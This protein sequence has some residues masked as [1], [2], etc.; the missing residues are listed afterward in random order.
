M[1]AVARLRAS[2][3][4]GC[5]FASLG[6]GGFLP[7]NGQA[8]S[9]VPE[10]VRRAASPLEPKETFLELIKRVNSRRNHLPF[11]VT[12]RSDGEET[13]TLEP[14][15]TP[16][17]EFALKVRLSDS[18]LSDPGAI[19]EGMLKVAQV[20]DFGLSGAEDEETG[21]RSIKAIVELLGLARGSLTEVA[22]FDHSTF[23]W[24]E[25]VRDAEMGSPRAQL[26]LKEMEAGVLKTMGE[27]VERSPPSHW[28]EANGKERI[29]AY[30]MR[31]QA[32]IE[33]ELSVSRAQVATLEAQVQEKWQDRQTKWGQ[34]ETT[35]KTLSE[36]VAREDRAGVRKLLNDYLPWELME[37]TEKATWTEWLDAIEKPDPSRMKIVF[38]GLARESVSGLRTR[39]PFLLTK[40]YSE[41]KL[42]EVERLRSLADIRERV[43]G[44]AGG[45][46][47]TVLDL[48]SS[49]AWESDSS[50][51]LS[52]ADLS[53]ATSFTK[54]TVGIFRIDE[55]RVMRNYSSA[56]AEFEKLVPLVVFPSEVV[57]LLNIRKWHGKTSDGAF[58][59]FDDSMPPEKK[60][61]LQ[62]SATAAQSKIAEA[63]RESIRSALGRDV[64]RADFVDQIDFDSI[65]A[66]KP[67]DQLILN[68]RKAG[69]NRRFGEREFVRRNHL[70]PLERVSS[71]LLKTLPK[72]LDQ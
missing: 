19:L 63:A 53:T 4:S 2:I 69:N 12:L 22:A 51:F 13:P 8:A 55:R 58:L 11:E 27:L 1:T 39:K 66:P 67:R 37:P 28:I 3:I 52:T 23:R 36:L 21:D 40:S 43:R 56:Y 25:I 6:I 38:R 44:N 9:P 32:A 70:K 7:S 57:K 50:V 42:P 68:L 48:L 34:T 62:A 17:G 61:K 29:R 18:A 59:G 14:A 47:M 30:L 71:C 33:R 15:A 45:G 49:H 31:R 60:A 16:E 5:V 26:K 65:V 64:K 41:S 35:G 24:A 54:D 20:T 10:A 46:P 72:L